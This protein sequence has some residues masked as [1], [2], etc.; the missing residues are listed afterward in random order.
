[1]HHLPIALLLLLL[2]SP[3]AHAQPEPYQKLINEGEWKSAYELLEP[4]LLKPQLLKPQL[5]KPQRIEATSTTA[6]NLRQRL[7]AAVRCLNEL[8][9][10]GDCETLIEAVVENYPQH[11]QTYAAAADAYDHLLS[12]GNLVE[13]EFR[14]GR[15]RGAAKVLNAT[16]RDRVRQLQLELRA[17]KLLE[18]DQDADP[19]SRSQSRS[20]LWYSIANRLLSNSSTPFTPMLL[21]TNLAELPEYAEGWYPSYSSGG[22][23]VDNEGQPIV[24]EIPTD[25]QSAANDGERWRW[26]LAQV[27]RLNPSTLLTGERKRAD[28]LLSQ[29]GVTTLRA[30][31]QWGFG[32]PVE[33]Q[34][35]V[36]AL[37]TLGEDE[38][39]ARLASGVKR[40]K[41]PAGHNPIA[42][43]QKLLASSIEQQRDF[44]AGNLAEGL[45]NLFQ[46]RRQ[47]DRAAEY[48]RIAIKHSSSSNRK[49]RESSLAQIEQ[50]WGQFGKVLT[51][52]ADRG[53][54]V[55]YR[56]RNGEKV[57]LTAQKID[58][59][60]LLTDVQSYLE[61]RPNKINRARLQINRLGLRFVEQNPQKYVDQPIASWSQPLKPAKGHFDRRVTLSTP[62]QQSGA[63]LVTA[64]MAAID[65]KQ[66]NTSKIVLWVADTSIVSKP[67]DG[68]MMYFVADARS[69]EPIPNAQV[70]FF[71]Y[72]QQRVNKPNDFR[73]FT[74]RFARKTDQQGMVLVDSEE[75]KKNYQWIAIAKTPQGRFAYLGFNGIW[76]SSLAR[77]RYNKAKAVVLTDRPVYRPGQQVNFKAWVARARY[78]RRQLDQANEAESEFAHKA[79]QVEIFNAKNEK[80]ET[81]QLTANAYGGVVGEYTPTESDPLGVYRISV[82]GYGQGTFRLEEYKKPEFEV[83]VDAP[84]DGV[85]LG[86]AFA[87]T[88]NARYYFGSPVTNATVQYKVVRS[89]RSAS[90]FPSMP[91]DWLYGPGYWWACGNDQWYPGW[92]R[93]GC[94]LPAPQWSSWWRPTPP[95]EV[96]AEGEAPLG[97]EGTLTISIDTALAKQM[98]S[99]SDHDYRITA[100]VTDESRRTIVGSGSA[101]AAR[102]TVQTVAWLDRGYYAIGE[103]VNVRIATRRPDGKPLAAGGVVRLLQVTYPASDV[104]AG[105]RLEPK[106]TEVRRWDLASGADGG[107][108]LQFK[109]SEPGRYRISYTAT[110]DAGEDKA[111]SGCLFT[112][113][114]EGLD[115]GDFEY[116]DLEIVLDAQQYKPGDKAQLRIHSNHRN[117]WV[118]LFLRPSRGVYPAPQ[119]VKLDGK[120]ATVPIELSRDDLP[121]CYVEAVTVHGGKVHRRVRELILPP[122]SRVVNVEVL[123]SAQA[124]LPGQEAT[125]KLR[126]TDQQGQPVVGDTVVSI[127][128]KSVDYI[129]GGGNSLNL[130]EYFWKWRRGHYPGG[131]HSLAR[132]GRNLV[133]TGERALQP[134]GTFGWQLEIADG[135][136]GPQ[137]FGPVNE[138]VMP[139]LSGSGGGVFGGSALGMTIMRAETRTRLSKAS[140]LK[141]DKSAD[142]ADTENSKGASSASPLVEANVRSEFADTALWVGSVVTDADGL[143]EV[144]LLMPENLTAWR[145]RVWNM[146]GGARVGQG[147]AEIVT[148]KNLLVRLQTP[149]FLVDTDEVVLS[150]NV[151]NYLEQKKQ[152]EVRLQL[153]GDCL[154]ALSSA[155][156]TNGGEL[157]KTIEVPAGGDVRVDWRVKAISEGEALVTAFALTDEES[158]AMQLKLPVQVH[159]AERIESFAGVVGE[160]DRIAAFEIIVPAERRVEQTRFELS[161]SPTL[162]GAMVEA[163]PY[164]IEY[165]HGCTEQTLNR[166]LPAVL[167]QR[168]LARMGVDLT[169]AKEGAGKAEEER[170]R[171]RAKDLLHR[172][173]TK[174]PVFD[175]QQLDKIV[176]VG[177]RRLQDMQLSDGGWGWF[178]GYGENSSA[179]TTAVVVRGLLLARENDV[180]IVDGVIDRGVTW[181]K[182]YQA[183]QLK[184]LLNAPSKTKPFKNKADNNDALVFS[185]LATA[186]ER[187]AQM[188]RL[189]FRDR[190]QLAPY[191]LAM[192]GLALHQHVETGRGGEADRDQVI[193]NLKQFVIT[194]DE[195]QTAYLD[196]P[197]GYW[198][199]WYGS[200]FETHAHFLK[201]LS[202]TEPHS[203]LTAGLVKYLLNNRRHATYWNSTRDTALV[204]EAMAD[205]LATSGEA[206]SDMQIEIWVDGQRRQESNVSA[207]EA[208]TFDGRFLL[209]GKQLEP[210]RHTVELRKKKGD[211]PGGRLYYN[212]TLTNFTLEDDIRAAGL[213]VKVRR[214]LFK[215]TPTAATT[216]VAN[217]S[218][219]PVTQRIE[220]YDRAEI[221]NLGQVTSGDLIE[222]ELTVESKNDYEYLLINSPKAAGFEPVEV[223]SGYN[224]NAMGAYVEYRDTAVHLFTKRL[225]RG[226]STVSY[227][228]RAEA[229]GKYSALPAHVS[230]MYAPELRGNSDEQKL[231]VSER[232]LVHAE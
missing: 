198:W 230:A 153:E 202:A 199:R 132:V 74:E 4:Q 16:E 81:R 45:A 36:Y 24:F 155:S 188:E 151:H 102:K 113:T 195:N 98:H 162:V 67:L 30:F 209:A 178:S 60:R 22:A 185:V 140:T 97:N 217:T 148:R 193:R 68:K 207:S 221:A 33:D 204:I 150:A 29:F 210:G 215:L 177:V 62:L 163:L 138:G 143:A 13:G 149:R 48:W 89:Q 64:K 130:R 131:V 165:P 32:S 93:W 212:A 134:L 25:W 101:L 44:E 1:M 73:V 227:R 219:R 119:M 118:L 152:V 191:T 190:L 55:D 82:R 14:R 51:Q 38:T 218:G 135:G 187:D 168:T 107:A 231:R 141:R 99:D 40:F 216:Q 112:I 125:V 179:H 37:H 15:N 117:G 154:E 175:K 10:Q 129:A 80:I 39:M 213:E 144:S 171:L 94:R 157:T 7:L 79:F 142:S 208:L 103:P 133:P 96:V 77:Q 127:Y 164:L 181:L 166:F 224:G 43:Y 182:R 108:Q 146:S 90:W 50:P 114:G 100:E 232:P 226:K 220:K 194:D 85:K 8:N 173:T 176:R 109:A 186:G 86:E 91:W 23:P 184:K 35:P 57:E 5:L 128:D 111:E 192:F 222:V 121:N 228:L 69:G 31:G 136:F 201:L 54:T 137:G 3:L 225:A 106:E 6:Q 115:T 214:K 58:V 189:L 75:V 116:D 72:R 123:P 61:S 196:L 206:A 20:Q 92:N 88:V 47:Y 158:D 49:S 105:E 66:G 17:T 174:N 205:Y 70:E 167:T 52:P 156:Q 200:E 63:Y 197:G 183:Q 53:A 27:D 11:W 180:A 12:Y 26:A 161:Y 56:F 84:A 59:E 159:G 76:R 160:S 124:Y 78:D 122:A 34:D 18:T 2:L 104:A 203:D 65:G 139:H 95:A 46:N 42:I 110:D 28:V 147:D 126:V 172:R 19:Q 170:E 87:A 229:P 41:F 145:V 71:G 9:R 83:T 21:K 169:K 223:R 120:S 211:Q